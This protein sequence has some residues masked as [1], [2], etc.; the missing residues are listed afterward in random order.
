MSSSV[1]SRG[2]VAMFDLLEQRWLDDFL[3]QVHLD[4]GVDRVD[5]Q[6]ALL[7]A[8]GHTLWFNYVV[9]K[10]W[11]CNP[12]ETRAADAADYLW[13]DDRLCAEYTL[14]WRA[15]I[16]SLANK[17]RAIVR[18]HPPVVGK[19]LH[20]TTCA[21][22]ETIDFYELSKVAYFALRTEFD[23]GDSPGQVTF[24]DY[25]RQES[26]VSQVTIWDISEASDLYDQMVASPKCNRVGPQKTDGS[27]TLY[28]LMID[29][30][31]NTD[32]GTPTTKL[33]DLL[34][35]EVE[36]AI[37]TGQRFD[38]LDL[39]GGVIVIGDKDMDHSKLYD[40]FALMRRSLSLV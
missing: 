20:H 24:S 13:V 23:R 19:E 15:R 1:Y 8:A 32:S 18:V 31:Q 39:L 10:S 16:V 21:W 38:D 14:E 6:A 4:D 12:P 2:G 36:L 34:I 9:S 22:L 27:R 3:Y 33:V 35:E 5:A 40:R 25:L 7:F 17:P 30:I 26:L 28:V 11:W 37:H 29:V